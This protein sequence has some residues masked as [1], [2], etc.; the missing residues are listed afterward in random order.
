MPKKSNA[1]EIDAAAV[2][3]RSSIHISRTNRVRKMEER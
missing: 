2:C 1:V 3:L